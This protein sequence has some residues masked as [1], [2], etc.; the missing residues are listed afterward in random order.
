MGICATRANPVTLA[1][2]LF[3]LTLAIYATLLG[4]GRLQTPARWKNSDQALW[5][6]RF[7]LLFGTLLLLNS[8]GITTHQICDWLQDIL[9]SGGG[10]GAG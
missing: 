4:L 2:A 1:L 7:S 6:G 9:T 3:L 8:F 5:T 10:G